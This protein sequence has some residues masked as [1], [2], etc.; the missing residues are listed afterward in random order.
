MRR[1]L[2]RRSL[3]A[4]TGQYRGINVPSLL[5]LWR[6]PSTWFDP[7]SLES[8]IIKDIEVEDAAI[9]A[10]DCIL[11]VADKR[12]EDIEIVSWSVRADSEIVEMS[13]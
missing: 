3:N 12:I 8:P 9:Y 7:D 5:K 1:G 4:K 11:Q 2:S 10:V 13:F 6:V